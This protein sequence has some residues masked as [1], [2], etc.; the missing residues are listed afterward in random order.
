MH[1][2]L[3]STNLCMLLV[4]LSHAA[5]SCQRC[6]IVCTYFVRL[7]FVKLL[8]RLFPLTPSFDQ[9]T[10]TQY[11]T[12]TQ[13]RRRFAHRK[14]YNIRQVYLMTGVLQFGCMS[15]CNMPYAHKHTFNALTFLNTFSL[16]GILLGDFVGVVL[17]HIAYIYFSESTHL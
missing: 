5:P 14:Q 9:V 7:S 8:K 17:K 13:N 2:S 10:Y 3:C 15:A 4:P 16:C 1:C 12:D 11:S 6:V